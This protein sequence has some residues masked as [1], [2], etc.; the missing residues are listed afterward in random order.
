MAKNAFL[1]ELFLGLYT[2]LL[3]ILSSKISCDHTMQRIKKIVKPSALG[4]DNV[5]IFVDLG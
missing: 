3:K 2:P 1:A 5:H 4:R